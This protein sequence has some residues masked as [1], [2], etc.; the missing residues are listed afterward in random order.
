MGATGLWYQSYPGQRHALPLYLLRQPLN[1]LIAGASGFAA[2]GADLHQRKEGRIL[3]DGGVDNPFV[4]NQMTAQQGAVGF[5]HRPLTEL[6]AEQGIDGLV[7]G[8]HHDA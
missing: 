6:L 8:H 3:G 5:A 7:S 2:G 4:V 1:H